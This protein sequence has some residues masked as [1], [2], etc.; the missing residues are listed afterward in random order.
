MTIQRIIF[1]VLLII[2][3]S[4]NR[5]KSTKNENKNIIT[6]IAKN[7]D[8]LNHIENKNNLIDS[9]T[10][11]LNN[12]IAYRYSIENQIQILLDKLDE[13]ES[14]DFDFKDSVTT[15]IIE[16][17]KGLRFVECYLKSDRKSA[18]LFNQLLKIRFQQIEKELLDD[19]CY[20]SDEIQGGVYFTSFSCD[21]RYISDYALSI[22][23]NVSEDCGGIHGNSWSICDNY[24]I[25]GERAIKVEAKDIF[26]NKMNFDTINYN[27]AKEKFGKID[28]SIT[29]R[30]LIFNFSSFKNHEYGEQAYFVFSDE[31]GIKILYDPYMRYANWPERTLRNSTQYQTINYDYLRPYMKPDIYELLTAGI[32]RQHD[33]DN[34]K[35]ELLLKKI[36]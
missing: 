29:P 21:I 1:I 3:A 23:F 22:L 9:L 36:E 34:K 11:K 8:T 30:E 27:F 6:P 16:K 28:T 26:R 14:L 12:Q 13:N 4:C 17:R 20:Y 31:F 33:N 2:H 35:R 15:T 25:K 10:K 24:I 7:N 19:G 32:K 18:K 5:T